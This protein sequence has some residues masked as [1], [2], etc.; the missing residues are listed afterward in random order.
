MRNALLLLWA[1]AASLCLGIAGAAPAAAETYT[2]TPTQD[3]EV[4]SDAGGTSQCGGC[5]DLRVRNISTGETRPLFQFDLS[6]IPANAT[7]ASAT[8]RLWV[9]VAESATT[10]IYRVTQPWTEYDLTWANSGGVSHNTTAVASFTPSV[11]GRSYDVNVTSLVN[12][13]RAGTANY[14]VILRIAGT[15]MEA[16]FKSREWGTAAERPQ[17]IV[18]ASV[19]PTFSLSVSSALTSDP[20]NGGTNPKRIPG[21]VLLYSSVVRNSSSGTPS[22][23]S[24]TVTEAVPAQTILYVG[25]LNGTG[26]GPVTF[27][28]GSPSSTLTYTYTSLASTTDDVSFSNNGGSTFTYTPVP[29]TSGYDANVTHVR[30]NPKG[31][32]AGSSATGNPSATIR[33]R[34][35]VR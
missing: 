23:N 8:L 2:L 7:V 13:W 32:F 3:T 11:S 4:R 22:A 24:V 31:T 12:Q 1:I 17:L 21:A 30:V 18:V 14:G 27:V 9:T 20:F 29:D 33:F 28:Q 16:S 5:N 19:A 25:D 26:T 6:S 35:K 10:S 34:L 15:S